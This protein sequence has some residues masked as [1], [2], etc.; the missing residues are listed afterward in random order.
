[1]RGTISGAGTLA[2]QWLLAG[3]AT[4]EYAG[5][6]K[7]VR[8]LGDCGPRFTDAQAALFRHGGRVAVSFA[9]R[10]TRTS[11]KVCPAG[12]LEGLT[13]AELATRVSCTV[14]G[15]AATWLEPFV[16]DGWLYLNNLRAAGI[17]ML[18]R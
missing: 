13:P 9:E 10:P 18:L 11:I 7:T 3:D 12:G 14:A 15:A 17:M 5:A 2:G 16:S 4:L 6:P 1:M 8:D